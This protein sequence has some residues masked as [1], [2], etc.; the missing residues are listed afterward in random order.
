MNQL[1]SAFI[2]FVLGFSVQSSFAAVGVGDTPPDWTLET[3]AGETINYYQ[4]SEGRVN[5]IFFWATW[6][7]YCRSLM[8]HLKLLHDLYRGKRVEFYALNIQENG[9]PV[10]YFEQNNFKFKLLLAADLVAEDYG[11]KGT[12]WLLV[13]D[14]NR[15]VIYR[16]PVGVTDVM[17]AQNIKYAIKKALA[18]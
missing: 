15:K 5:V 8:P 2:L 14:K 7:P 13:I 18:Q 16:R 10:A 11:V 9:D 17:V 6:C 4:D 3:P 1:F 12:P